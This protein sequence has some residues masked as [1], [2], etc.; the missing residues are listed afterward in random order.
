MIDNVLV[1]NKDEEEQNKNLTIALE[2]IQM[3]GLTLNENKCHFC[4]NRITFLCQIIVE[5]R[6][7]L[8]SDNF[9]VFKK[10][11]TPENVRNIRHFLMEYLIC[12][13]SL[14]LTWQMKQNL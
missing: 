14:Y 8:D 11:R 12:C 13:V 2:R 6:V 9:S 3:S 10:I 4:T 5:P 7:S 1:F